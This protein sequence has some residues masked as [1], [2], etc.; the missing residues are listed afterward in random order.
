MSHTTQGLPPR[1]AVLS[2]LVAFVGP[3]S[4]ADAPPEEGGLAG[5]QVTLETQQV[6]LQGSVIALR[7][8]PPGLTLVTAAHGLFPL[9]EG[10]VIALRPVLGELAIRGTVESAQPNPGYRPVRARDPNAPL[11]Y[12]GAIGSDNSVVTLRL[13]IDGEDQRRAFR[14]LRP[15][16][17]A[18]RPAL[19]RGGGGVLTVHVIDRDG[20]EHV[21]RAGN[22]MN[23]RW[24]A[25]G[26]KYH[27][28]PGDSGAGVFVVIDPPERDGATAGAAPARAVLIGNVVASD[29]MGGIAALFSQADFPALAPPKKPASGGSP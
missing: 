1:L 12:Q 25:W 15:V 14:L 28:Q 16:P 29:A 4:A 23:P 18:T 8:D 17:V 24:L 7:Q 6:T 20:I 26:P 27:P 9:D 10:T 21:V 3:L 11:Q 5:S 22:A 13:T 2:L 19:G